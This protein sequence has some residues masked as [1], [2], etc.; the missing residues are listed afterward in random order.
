MTFGS[1]LPMESQ[2]TVSLDPSKPALHISV[3][4]LSSLMHPTGGPASCVMSFTPRPWWYVANSCPSVQGG[5]LPIH[6]VSSVCSEQGIPPSLVWDWGKE[7]LRKIKHWKY[8][9][10]KLPFFVLKLGFSG[11]YL[12]NDGPSV[13]SNSRWPTL[14][15]C[16]LF[17][18]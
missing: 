18:R 16:P 4:Y 9:F 7:V 1:Y 5:I 15:E 8:S 6:S 13:M 11:L 14:A 17:M 2:G 10:R 3:D 12:I